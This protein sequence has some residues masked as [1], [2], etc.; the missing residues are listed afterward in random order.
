M[1]SRRRPRWLLDAERVDHA[2][3]A[4]VAATPT[5]SLDR[6]MI[7]LSHAADG[8]VL[9]IATASALAV[10]RGPRGRRAAGAGLASIAV[11][12]AA[13]NL[14]AKPLAR[15]RRPDRIA[16]QVP[17]ARHV[18][19]PASR[20]LPS[21]HAASAFAFATGAGHALHRESAA[22][23]VLAALVAYSRVHTGV[24]FPA[25]VVVGSLMGTVCSATATRAI[26]RRRR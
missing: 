2:I 8:S 4:A 18:P 23:R 17:V 12:S 19:M 1:T 21:G 5:P 22:L 13:V 9:W 10:A 26:E 11:T 16:L 20:S 3:Y 14:V 7:A 6:F 24:H 15:R 25:D